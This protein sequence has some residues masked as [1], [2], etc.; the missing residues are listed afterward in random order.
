LSHFLRG[1]G[2][3]KMIIAALKDWAV[4]K[5]IDELRL[6]VYFPNSPAIRA[7]EKIG[8]SKHMIEMRMK[9]NDITL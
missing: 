1:R 9:A 6:E 7:Y 2:I 3:N 5:N 8:F 4:S